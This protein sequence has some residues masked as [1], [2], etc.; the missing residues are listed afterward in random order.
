V[1]GAIA[2]VAGYVFVYNKPH[3]DFEKASASY[4]MTSD[5]I[6]NA[7]EADEKA[8]SAKYQDA[9][10]LITGPVESVSEVQDGM[11]QVVLV[12][13]NAMLGGVKAQ[14]H[15]KYRDYESHALQVSTLE[16]GKTATLKCRCVGMDA[17]VV[18]DNCFITEK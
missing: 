12:A 9:V 4:T 17:E 16:E 5:E 10:I 7:F 2:A 14:L 13:E 8:A 11:I 1:I 6:Y 15:P 18:M 3:R